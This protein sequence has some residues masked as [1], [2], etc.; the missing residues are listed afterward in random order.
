[1]L[2]QADG[3]VR[4][5]R[6]A[7]KT[8]PIDGRFLQAGRAKHLTQCPGSKPMRGVVA[9]SYVG[10]GDRRGND[11]FHGARF[12]IERRSRVLPRLARSRASSPNLARW[13]FSVAVSG[14]PSQKAM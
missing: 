2:S 12:F 4:G 10:D 3:R 7:G 5:E 13:I 14:R 9:E 1:M 6:E 11:S 8:Q